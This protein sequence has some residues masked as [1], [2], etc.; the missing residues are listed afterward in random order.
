MGGYYDAAQALHGF[1][2]APNGVCTAID[3]PGADA[4]IPSGINNAGWIVGEEH[5]GGVAH[6]FVRNPAGLITII[7]APGASFTSATGINASGW[8]VGQY[9]SATTCHGFL[10]T[11]VPE[12]GS[13]VL[14]A[15]VLA[16]VA[17]QPR[18]RLAPR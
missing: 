5:S 17:T 2:R 3:V 15:L 14:L 7:D 18:R 12:P 13:G 10:A 11:P 6:A 4:T 16:A 9:C 8:L 1:T